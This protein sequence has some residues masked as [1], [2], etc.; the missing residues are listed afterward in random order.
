MKRSTASMTP[1]ASADEFVH[2]LTRTFKSMADA[3]R[4]PAM[5]AYMRGIAP[6]LGIASPERVRAVRTVL[7]TVGR[8]DDL[9]RCA[10]LLYACAERE[11]HYAAWDVCSHRTIVR[12]LTPE[13][14]SWL[15]AFIGRHS[16][17]DTVDYLVP[18]VIGVILRAHPHLLRGVTAP[19]IE[20]DDIW[21]QRAAIIVQLGWK[22]ATQ[23]D[24]LTSNVLRR[25]DSAEFFVRKG[26]GWALREYAYTDPKAVYEFVD[27]NKHLL[28]G[29]TVR[30]ALK[31]RDTAR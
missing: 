15:E 7:D 18:R 17:W 22:T 3:Q 31:H 27:R 6:F 20:S 8:P 12:T 29:L 16:W 21:Y 26:A 4:A 13:D 28:S 10:E 25:A 1:S 9:A 30:E 14:V 11:Y 23:F 24:V 5:S 19:W 2:V